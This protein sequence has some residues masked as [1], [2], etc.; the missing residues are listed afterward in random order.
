MS[1]SPANLRL[2]IGNITTTTTTTAANTPSSCAY[3]TSPYHTPSTNTQTSPYT[4]TYTS[5]PS[6]SNRYIHTTNRSG[7]QAILT[8]K[9][10]T[11]I[12]QWIVSLLA[13]ATMSP[14]GKHGLTTG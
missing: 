1:S 5:S 10:K 13:F 4:Y 8:G 6:S 11:R 7:W 3:N 9:G 12:V 2:N 14:A